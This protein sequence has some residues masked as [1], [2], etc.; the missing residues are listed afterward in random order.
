VDYKLEYTAGERIRVCYLKQ[1]EIII[2]RLSRSDLDLRDDSVSRQHCKLI[3]SGNGYRL[4]DLQS[5]NGSYV[6]GIKVRDRLLEE[7]DSIRVGRTLLRFLR[8]RK[9]ESYCDIDDQEISMKAALAEIRKV[10]G[11]ISEELSLLS[12]LTALGRDVILSEDLEDCFRKIA[13]FVFHFIGPEKVHIFSYGATENDLH[14]KYSHSPGKEEPVRISKTI[15]LKAI[16]ERVAILSASTRE[17]ARFEESRSV[18]L[19]GITSAMSVPIWTLDAIHG[20]IYVDT[21]R[22][23]KRFN[24]KDLEVMS[25]IANFAGL[26]IEALDRLEKLAAEKKMRA[27]LER[28][29]SPGV[30]GRLTH[31]QSLD[32]GAFL[33]YQEEEASVLFLD[34]VGFTGRAEKMSPLQVG[35]FLNN[36]F[37][38][39][40]EVIFRHDGTLDKFIGDA[41]MAIFGAPVAA[42]NHPE[43]AVLA[44]VEMLQKLEEMNSGLPEHERTRVRIGVHSGK[45]ISGDFGSPKRLEYTVLG[46]TVNIASRL[47]SAVAAPDE[48]VV[49]ETV[50]AATRGEFEFEIIGDRKLHGISTPVKTYKVLWKK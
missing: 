44:G 41:I 28:Y 50:Y 27:R 26:S 46:N 14:L 45:L 20:L 33:P 22:P 32:T 13:G 49:S 17:D 36:F 43:L 25:L 34:I 39:M 23:D 38:E 1:D 24:E 8:V 10:T 9:E 42:A 16:R 40:T 6:N 31:F 5:A 3:K 2:G 15:A 30:I 11:D 37:T 29:H 21:T 7:G 12:S 18:I 19:Y 47:Q 35:I 48:M 4:I